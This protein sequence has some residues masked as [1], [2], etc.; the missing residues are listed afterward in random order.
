MFVYHWLKL[1]YSKIK[2]GLTG[3]KSTQ[4]RAGAVIVRTELF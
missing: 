3:F 2:Y 1:L 4:Y